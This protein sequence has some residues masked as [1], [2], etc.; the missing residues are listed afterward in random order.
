MR[1]CQISSNGWI[2]HP[3]RAR[4]RIKVIAFFGNGQRHHMD[5]LVSHGRNQSGRVFRRDKHVL[6]RT[7]DLCPA[8]GTF[9]DEACIKPILRIELVRDLRAAQAC[10]QNAPAK[11]A[12][13]Q[14]GLGKDGLMGAVKGTHTQMHLAHAH[15]ASIIGRRF[16]AFWKLVVGKTFHLTTDR[17][18]WPA[19]RRG[20]RRLQPPH[21]LLAD[22][23][24]P[25]GPATHNP[26]GGQ[27][28][29]GQEWTGRRVYRR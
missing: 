20:H 5:V 13:R 7:D 19:D 17:L 12:C 21:R 3:Q 18:L 22:G 27:H 16:S 25:I 23:H 8:V 1:P 9:A 28:H 26:C 10:P 11:I 24:T 29:G 2:V 4:S 15:C 6:D 14:T